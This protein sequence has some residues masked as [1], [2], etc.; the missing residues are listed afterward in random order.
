MNQF[1]RF[2]I[3]AAFAAIAFAG[4]SSTDTPLPPTYPHITYVKETTY[5]YYQVALDSSGKVVAGSGDTIQST[6]IDTALLFHGK[7]ATVFANTHTLKNT[8]NDTTYIAQDSGHFWHYNY[9]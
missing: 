4:C 3:L 7:I 5:T 8:P 1:R 2:S 6:V 9:G